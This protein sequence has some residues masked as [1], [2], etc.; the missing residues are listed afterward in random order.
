MK[1][2]VPEMTVNT[3]TT[4]SNQSALQPRKGRSQVDVE[5]VV[6]T[7]REEVATLVDALVVAIVPEGDNRSS[8]RTRRWVC[9]LLL[10]LLQRVRLY[11][12]KGKAARGAHVSATISGDA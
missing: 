2:V 4:I 1:I 12:V 3:I 8:R 9:D 6:L 10:L 11:K 5:E 7:W